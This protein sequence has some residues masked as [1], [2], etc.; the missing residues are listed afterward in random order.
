MCGVQAQLL[1]AT[2]LAIWARIEDIKRGDLQKQLFKD[3]IL[4]RTWS[5]RGTLHVLPSF[6][7]Q[8]YVGALKTRTGYRKGAWLRYFG[9]SLEEIDRIIAATGKALA[10]GPLTKKE[11]AEKISRSQGEHLREKFLSG[12]GE[13]LKPA[14]YNGLLA[15]GPDRDGEVTYIRADKWLG[16]EP[17]KDPDESMKDVLRYYLCSYGPARHEDFARWWGTEP[18]PAKRLFKSI[19]EELLQVDVEGCIGSMLRKDYEVI[20]E[21]VPTD[22]VRLLPNFDSYVLGFRPRDSFVP[23]DKA[24][25]VFRPQAWVSPVLLVDGQIAGIWERS[26]TKGGAELGIT[27]FTRLTNDQREVLRDEV[28]RMSAYYGN[29]LVLSF[30]GKPT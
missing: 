17:D 15:S 8:T 3:R 27:M 22:S 5:M 26:N 4:F 6:Q 10:T 25:L 1:P 7:F 18:A 21:S 11:L 23:K 30:S 19:E 28:G 13:L 9:V 24:D 14:A 12:W 16:I 29:D 2:E 20:E